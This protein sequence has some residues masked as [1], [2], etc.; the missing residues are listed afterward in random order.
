RPLLRLGERGAKS[1][2]QEGIELRQLRAEC[3]ERTVARADVGKNAFAGDTRLGGGADFS[4]RIGVDRAVEIDL[5][6]GELVDV[7]IGNV[8]YRRALDPGEQ[9][10][11]GIGVGDGEMRRSPQLGAGE[12][13]KRTRFGALTVAPVFHG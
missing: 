3:R 13:G 4:A 9:T 11:M 1:R 12:E 8:R 5:K 10:D 2:L 6:L 7:R